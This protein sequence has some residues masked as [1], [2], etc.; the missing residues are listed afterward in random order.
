[1]GRIVSTISDLIESGQGLWLEGLAGEHAAIS[2]LADNRQRHSIAGLSVT[3]DACDRVLQAGKA[4]DRLIQE[5]LREG[6]YGGRLAMELLL[7]DAL[8]AADLLLP[9]FEQSGGLNGWVAVPSSPLS[10]SDT[11]SIRPRCPDHC[12]TSKGGNT[13]WFK[14]RPVDRLSAYR[15]R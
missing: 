7:A 12:R 11:A 13:A 9:N 4:F 10:T 14:I 6:F 2:L 15:R 3:L 8:R 5:K 1:M